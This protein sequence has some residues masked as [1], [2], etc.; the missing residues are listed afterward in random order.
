MKKLRLM[1]ASLRGRIVTSTLGAVL[2]SLTLCVA[3]LLLLIANVMGSYLQNE[4]DFAM[5]EICANL[6]AKTVFLEDAL[7]SLRENEAL[8]TA[9]HN[10][11]LEEGEAS[12]TEAAFR[13]VVSV[14]SSKNTDLTQTPFLEAAWLFDREGRLNR[15]TYTE[16]LSEE[17]QLLDAHYTT[18]N[19]AF[20]ASGLDGT[21]YTGDGGMEVA[22]VVYD[23]QMRP[24][25]N[26]IFTL[27]RE[28][29][30]A[31]MEKSVQYRDG[32]WFLFDKAGKTVLTGGQFPL[33]G[34]Q[35][36]ELAVS[37]R[38]SPWEYT[39]GGVRCR[40]YTQRMS[41][42][43]GAAVGVPSDQLSTLL[44][45]SVK[46]YL[47]VPAMLMAALGGVLFVVMMRLTR[48]LVQ[49][50]DSL[51]RVAGQDFSVRLP[52]YGSIE[53]DAIS[54]TFN[55]MTDTINRLINDVYEK[56]LLAM[57]SEMRFLQSQ[58]NPHFMY[59]VL[60]TIAL[61]A[62]LDGNEEISRMA[63]NFSGLTQARL[64]HQNDEKLTVE[65]ELQL[66]RFYLDLQKDRFEDKLSYHIHV[67]EGVDRCRLP[68]LAM[69]FIVEN[70][71]VHGI[72]PKPGP[73]KV[74]VDVSR[75]GKDLVIC[76]EDDGVGFDEKTAAERKPGHNHVALDN[77]RKMIRLNY[78]APYGVTV[79]SRPGVG[80]IAVI[81]IPAD[82]EGVEEHV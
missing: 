70:A 67:E 9:L 61:R 3:V 59:N 81:R 5:R 15:T 35:A 42:G 82:E 7:L 6:N 4:V 45:D 23:Q 22:Y 8:M 17:Q 56:K 53:F 26:I 25:G 1:P 77:V 24:V 12:W 63:S 10:G 62:K 64:Y 65:E 16:Y 76:I 20:T 46:I 44:F 33:N 21:V 28:A 50:A 73:G 2:L 72:E 48:P 54:D 13:R 52:Q 14:Y 11:G 71:V 39:S 66:V 78:G 40:V 68:K 37:G 69:E 74:Y 57:E 49:V 38:L 18:L 79:Q 29:V 30:E 80:T 34:A 41:M 43:L 60:N 36:Q 47:L 58:M 55:S 32:F 51:R 31:L 19:A 75:D 27:H